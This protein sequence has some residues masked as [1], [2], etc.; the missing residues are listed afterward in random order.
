MMDSKETNQLHC[1]TF[2]EILR[3]PGVC[4][5]TLSVSLVHFTPATSSKATPSRQQLEQTP[6]KPLRA[7]VPVS[8]KGKSML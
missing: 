4:L 3:G 7:V 1:C 8:A 6:E 2:G 5:E